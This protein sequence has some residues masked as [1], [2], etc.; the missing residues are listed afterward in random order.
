MCYLNQMCFTFCFSIIDE[1]IQRK[2]FLI[3]KIIYLHQRTN[4]LQDTSTTSIKYSILSKAES[5]R[6]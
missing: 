5:Q 1:V 6:M 4:I 3:L 2:Y